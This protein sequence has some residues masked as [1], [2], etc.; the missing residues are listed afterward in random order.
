MVMILPKSIMLT[1]T[2]LKCLEYAAS[3]C[4]SIALSALLAISFL[5]RVSIRLLQYTPRIGCGQMKNE[6][7]F[8]TISADKRLGEAEWGSE[9]KGHNSRSPETAL[10]SYKLRLCFLYRRIVGVQGRHNV[11]KVERDRLAFRWQSVVIDHVC[12]RKVEA[13]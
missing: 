12:E 3:T 11:F 5:R 1:G 2:Q 4:L 8:Q 13:T 10:R 6:Q 9:R 7:I